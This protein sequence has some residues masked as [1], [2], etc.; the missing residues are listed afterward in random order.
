MKVNNLI[1]YVETS[2]QGQYLHQQKITLI[3][4]T[5]D[6]KDI[7]W[8]YDRVLIMTYKSLATGFL[9]H[10]ILDTT[11]SPQRW[12]C[13]KMGSSTLGIWGDWLKEWDAMKSLANVVEISEKEFKMISYTH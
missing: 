12:L 7:L 6:T 9:K 1:D 11:W 3:P 13:D 5:W 8:M 4:L 10:Y 2:I